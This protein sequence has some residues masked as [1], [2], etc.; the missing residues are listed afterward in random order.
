MAEILSLS[1]K[2]IDR[3]IPPR[4]ETL[5][6]HPWIVKPRKKA[7]VSAD[8]DG[9]I[10]FLLFRHLF[11]WELG[12][13]YNTHGVAL[14]K[15]LDPFGAVGVDSEFLIQTYHS[16]GHHFSLSFPH[17]L[18]VNYEA[19]VIP[20]QGWLLDPDLTFE[21]L[22]AR[23]VKKYNLALAI[24]LFYLFDVPLPHDEVAL[25]FLLKADSSYKTFYRYGFKDDLNPREHLE[26]MKMDLILEFLLA[27][28]E[29]LRD[30]HKA[31]DFEDHPVS[32]KI[33]QLT[34]PYLT[35]MDIKDPNRPFPIHTP[36]GQS[37]FF[38][39]LL[40][41]NELF[42]FRPLLSHEI[43]GDYE[44]R[45]LYYMQFS[46]HPKIFPE[47][48][49]LGLWTHAITRA[50]MREGVVIGV[51]TEKPVDLKGDTTPVLKQHLLPF[52]Y[53]A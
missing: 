27:D 7:I 35:S 24:Y 26:A 31:G 21:T 34:S 33:T 41:L 51:T 43:E 13:L 14:K 16:V 38:S 50:N 32:K 40:L 25:S 8:L 39:F 3:K 37:R 45:R 15:G 47:L 44:Y 48:I 22:Q 6:R 30:H 9:A 11:G 52:R 23:F 36:E 28:D 19:N 42:G 10:S 46:Y 29:A 20:N 4:E 53:V 2:T 5:R 17:Q 18:S 1:S 49:D 12:G